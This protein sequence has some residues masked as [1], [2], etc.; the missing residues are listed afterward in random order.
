MK[1]EKAEFGAMN[2][3]SFVG[4]IK[5]TYDEL[6]SLFGELHYDYQC[7]DEKVQYEWDIKFEDGNVASIYDWKECGMSKHDIIE[8]HVGGF[9]KKALWNV[10]DIIESK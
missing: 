6:V 5:C 2:G 3:T 10:M 1:F 7:R 9:D 4:K 8:W